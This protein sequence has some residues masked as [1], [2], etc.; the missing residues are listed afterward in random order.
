L[1]EKANTSVSRAAFARIAGVRPSSV[2]RAIES[3]LLVADASGLLDLTNRDNQEY[4]ESHWQIQR[5]AR[6]EALLEARR[7]NR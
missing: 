2:T 3:G 5:E 6:L 1:R 4:I 7:R